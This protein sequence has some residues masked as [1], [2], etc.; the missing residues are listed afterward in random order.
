ME[1][2]DSMW[3]FLKAKTKKKK[4]SISRRA[5]PMHKLSEGRLTFI[6]FWEML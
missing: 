3:D 4:R 2:T 1:L 6:V 5:N